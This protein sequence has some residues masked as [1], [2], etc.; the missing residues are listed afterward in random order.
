MLSVLM[1]I[2]MLTPKFEIL[3]SDL[4]VILKINAPFTKIQDVE[5]T[6]DENQ[7]I[8]YAKPYYLK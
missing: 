1:Q 8:F 5:I 3:Q 4:C 7:F 6:V 2:N